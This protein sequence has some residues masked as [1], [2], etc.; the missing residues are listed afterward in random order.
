MKPWIT[1]LVTAITCTGCTTL[2]LERHTLSQASSSQPIRYQE[3][4]D[5]LAMIAHEPSALPVYASI[6]SGTA[7]LTDTGQLMSTTMWQHVRGVGSQNGFASEALAPQVMRS[8][9]ETWP[10]DPVAVPEKLEAMRAACQWV[11][12]GPNMLSDQDRSLLADPDEDPS[13]GRHFGVG[14]RLAQLRPGWVHRGRFTQ[15]PLCAA[16][17]AHFGNT[18]VWVMPEDTEELSSFA[19]AFQ[20]IARVS[21]NSY[22]LF[23]IP[24]APANTFSIYTQPA[25]LPNRHLASVAATV[26]VLPGLHLCPDVPYY[27]WREDNRGA[28]PPSLQSKLS[29]ATLTP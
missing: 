18:W 19:L 17:K 1:A 10:L 25:L 26:Y 24:P 22:T 11:V 23:Y 28:L 8:I 12:F 4:L 27:P 20:D 6:A 7:N 14:D 3:V 9:S 13:P 29:S 16:Y 5:N 2:S 15:I 21:I